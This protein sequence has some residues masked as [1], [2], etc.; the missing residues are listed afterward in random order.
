MKQLT[1]IILVFTGFCLQAQTFSVKGTLMHCHN[2]E[3]ACWDLNLFKNDSLIIQDIKMDFGVFVLDNIEEGTYTFQFTN[4]FNQKLNKEVMLRKEEVVILCVDE[5]IETNELT[6]FEN[7]SDKDELVIDFYSV[8]CFHDEGESVKFY[9]KKKKLIAELNAGKK[10]IRRRI[11]EK[12]LA[13]LIGFERRLRL[14]K[15]DTEL[16]PLLTPIHSN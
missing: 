5:F 9:Y 16:V 12:D 11:Q 14:M 7:L 2:D 15:G 8:G 4:I 10:T 1:I 13:Y 3:D 6:I